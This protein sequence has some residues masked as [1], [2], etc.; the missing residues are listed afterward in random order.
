MKRVVL[1][2]T[3][4]FI[5]LASLSGCKELL[6]PTQVRF[7]NNSTSKTVEAIWDG[8]HAATLAPGQTSEYSEQNPGTHT[9]QW[10]NH[11][12]GQALTTIAWPSLVEGQSYT[13]PYTD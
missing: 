9:I 2:A 11:S 7:Q 3:L 10:Q 12:N 6:G 5:L 4:C 1:I 8:S 13:F